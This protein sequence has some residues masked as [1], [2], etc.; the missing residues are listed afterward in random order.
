[1]NHMFL[2]RN[3]GFKWYSDGKIYCK[4]YLYI[5]NNLFLEGEDLLA[6]LTNLS[7]L[8]EVKKMLEK[9]DGFYSIIFNHS[10]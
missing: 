3:E 8:N 2:K 9:S 10:E 5:N 1:M 7:E 4:G 6:Y